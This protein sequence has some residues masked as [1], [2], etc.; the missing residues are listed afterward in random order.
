MRTGHPRSSGRSSGRS[1][2]GRVGRVGPVG[3]A[4]AVV[5]MVV[6]AA[7]VGPGAYGTAEAAG[8]GRTTPSSSTAGQ[9]VV[10][11]APGADLAALNR[12][13]GSTTRSAL[14]ASHSVY[15]LD[16]PLQQPS[17][18]PAKLEQN[19]AGQ[20]ARIVHDLGTDPAVVYAEINTEA[21]IIQGERFHYWPSGG[22]TCLGS[23]SSLYTDQSAARKLNLAEIH[24]EARGQGEVIAVLDTGVD[25]TQ[26]ALAGRE[27]PGGYDYVDDDAVPDDVRD[28][29]DHDGDLAQ[30][31]GYGH[32]T[33]V[34]GIAALVA[35]DAEILPERV[36]DPDGRGNVFVVAEAIYDAVTAHAD[37]IN[38][39]FGTAGKV[40][41]KVL[42]DAIRTAEHAGVVVTAAAGNDGSAQPHYPA[43]M[44]GVVGVAAQAAD[45]SELAA[46]S[47]RGGWVDVAAPGED[48]VSTLPCGYSSWSGTSMASP[49]VAGA[50]A[51]LEG[52]HPG[53]KAN[54]I[55]K[56][57]DEGS[58]KVRGMKVRGGVINLG[59]SMARV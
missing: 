43:A 4:A 19:W 38:M 53:K 33:F 1:P 17:Q 51:V 40:Q 58:D 24:R 16:V 31:E 30:D 6:G 7:V 28:G 59:R 45:S 26:P 49:F 37:V 25:F 11:L 46:F 54:E 52:I 10:K 8:G 32:G 2:G 39:S 55:V 20:A 34:A 50:A 36:L 12:K 14:L 22:P 47:A 5:V 57:I 35:P 23:D 41:S 56:A 29:V 42:Q 27:A 48:V 21:D 18:D 9:L 44:A 15:L 3:R 13:L